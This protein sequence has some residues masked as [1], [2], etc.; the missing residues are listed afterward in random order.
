MSTRRSFFV[1]GV[2][3]L[4]VMLLVSAAPA[5]AQTTAAPEAPTLSSVVPNGYGALLVVWNRGS[6]DATNMPSGF[7][8]RYEA[9]ETGNTFT[10]VSDMIMKVGNTTT[11]TISGLKHGT[12]Y[13]VQVRARNSEGNSIWT[14]PGN[15]SA[16]T[17][18]T[19]PM[20]DDGE[21][22][23]LTAMDMAIMAEWEAGDGN[24]VD[25]TGYEVQIMPMG[26]AW[27]GHAHFG[28]ATM[29]T[30]GGLTNGTEYS[31]RVRTLNGFSWADDQGWS[32]VMKATPMAGAGT[33]TPTTTPALPV[34]G[35]FAL[36]AGLLA[37]GRRRLRRRQQLLN[38]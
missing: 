8:V 37:A 1:T 34:F 10:G 38:S 32:D 15:E 30:I 18:L 20:P 25:P 36:G 33:P 21:D 7:D 5:G 29:T 9:V 17:T 14:S 31:V 16:E 28:T 23:T 2:L 27:T 6:Q 19:V 11:A 24:G 4:A 3:L 35:A 22:L 12:R 26:K 13:L